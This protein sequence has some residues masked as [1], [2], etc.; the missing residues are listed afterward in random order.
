MKEAISSLHFIEIFYSPRSRFMFTS[1][2]FHTLKQSQDFFLRPTMATQQVLNTVELLELILL[3][4]DWHNQLRYKLVCKLWRDAI[5]LSIT[6]RQSMF[7]CPP[8]TLPTKSVPHNE[9][10]SQFP[11]LD[12]YLD[13]EWTDASDVN[14]NMS[15]N[16]AIG[17]LLSHPKVVRHDEVC[18]D[19]TKIKLF[20]TDIRPNLPQC[21]WPDDVIVPPS[22][23][24]A[25]MFA[26]NP[27]LTYMEVSH[28]RPCCGVISVVNSQG[29]RISD[30]ADAFRFLIRFLW[31]CPCDRHS[32]RTQR[33]FF[34]CIIHNSKG[35]FQSF[36]HLFPVKMVSNYAE[37][38]A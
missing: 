18:G 3:Q 26:T 5:N 19:Q 13:K 25:P 16:P 7:I 2:H 21:D 36:K 6:L 27:P 14:P 30:L 24:F 29:I 37:R 22:K 28:S 4:V 1:N 32:P 23:Y 11:K 35:H 33:P 38:F 20:F 34:T 10:L 17:M 12:M 8:C 9:A 15:I 31:T